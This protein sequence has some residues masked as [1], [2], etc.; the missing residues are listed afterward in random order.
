[1]GDR[2]ISSSVGMAGASAP[3]P[4]ARPLAELTAAAA[5]LVLFLDAAVET[6]RAESGVRWWVAGAA[7]LYAIATAATWR[8]RIAWQ[9]R[10]A[11][12]VLGMLGLIAATAWWPDGLTE[13]IRVVGQ[14]TP[15]VLAALAA[16]GVALAGL[17]LAHLPNLHLT[18]RGAIGALALYGVCAFVMA[19]IESRSLAALFAGES[20][21]QRLPAVLQG[22]FIGGVLVLPLGLISSLARTGLRRPPHM[23]MRAEV[24]KL[25]AL[26]TSMAI[27]LAGLPLRSRAA[28]GQPPTG[29]LMSALGIDPR[30]PKP[31]PAALNAALANSLRA[32]ED[33]ER[34]MAR[35]R[36]DP[37]YVAAALGSDP[38]RIFSWVQASTFW[39]PYRGLLRGPVGVLMDRLGNSLD[40]AVLL[41]TLLGQAGRPV[42]LARGPLSTEQAIRVLGPLIAYR[43][44]TVASGVAEAEG[45]DKAS[46]IARAY[47]LDESSIRRTL[48]AQ[49]GSLLRKGTHLLAQ[50]PD[51]TSRLALAVGTRPGPATT[52]LQRALEALQDHWWVQALDGGTWQDFD[53]LAAAAGGAIA[54][55]TETVSLD[56]VPTELRH[57]FT[58]RVIAE[59]WINGTL[60]ER[61][62]LQHT[63]VPADLIGTPIVLR[64]APAKWPKTFPQRDK[65][66]QDSLRTLALEQQEWTPALVVGRDPT[67]QSTIR[68]NGELTPIK[69]AQPAPAG[70]M[71]RL[72]DALNDAL[73]PT[74]TP[75]PPPASTPASSGALTSAWIE[76]ELQR[77]GEPAE[78]TRRA[79]FDLI[80]PAAR[81]ARPTEAPRIDDTGRL[82]R[83]LALMM[84]TEILPIVCRVDPGYVTHLAAQSVLANRDL[85]SA[86]VR[87]DFTE[88]FAGA[89]QVAKRLAPLPTRLYGLAL[90]RFEWSRF[91]SLI[92]ID[93]PNVLTRHVF[94]APAAKGFKLVAATDIVAN[95]V[96]VDLV[97]A[98]PSA[99]RLAQGVLDTN[100]EAIL[101]SDR[102]NASNAGW[103]FAADAS[104]MTLRSPGDPQLG[105]LQLSDDVRRRIADDLEAGY[106]V[107]APKAPVAVG[108]EAFSGWWRINPATGH[109]LG[110]GSTGWGQEYVEYLITKIPLMMLIEAGAIAFL[111]EYLLCRIFMSGGGDGPVARGCEPA[112]DRRLALTDFFV[113]PLHAAG[114]N[115][116]ANAL[117][118]AL[119]AAALG[120]L[121]SWAASKYGRGGGGGKADPS[122]KTQPDPAAKTPTDP[123]G[124][125]QAD[126]LAKTEP[127]PGGGNPGPPGK[128]SPDGRGAK[129]QE[130][131][132]DVE[133]D[134]AA[135]EAA[136][137]KENDAWLKIWQESKTRADAEKYWQEWLDAWT[138]LSRLKVA[139]GNKDMVKRPDY[140]F[141]EMWLGSEPLP[142]PPGGT[143]LRTGPGGTQI[144]PGPGGTKIIPL[145]SVSPT[146]PA[147]PG[148]CPGPACPPTPPTKAQT[149]LGGVLN[150]LG[151]KS[152]G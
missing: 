63:L 43:H 79:V 108:N 31:P 103:A 57:Q 109:A 42:R 26:T 71:S 36:W 130:G 149:G 96:G 16:A 128:P 52:R 61:T 77:P 39:I 10:L 93:R 19:A 68:D 2:I 129:T 136:R 32:I 83:S 125:T 33:G 35:D 44:P 148:L 101:D 138:A 131:R 91:E 22:A 137:Q 105:A 94:V 5:G 124:K 122:A 51:Q 78:K 64:F 76:Y 141:P 85:L 87:G 45:A 17:A 73:G 126:P 55:P 146:T 134:G 18:I 143:P 75:A 118:A 56:A 8:M 142:A 102:P 110:F 86:A 30:A 1:M 20:L 121:G 112:S 92:H 111:F 145:P 66:P 144:I 84:E 15:T 89:Q 100:A 114:S 27:V 28:G 123:S 81:A 14:P 152:G 23:T 98:D 119:L 132:W 72:T 21:W 60:T 69:Q 48:E 151:Q 9:G 90:A 88:D 58:V 65:A 24:W 62:A 13:G 6:F 135:F 127:G 38:Q 104:W 50:V 107:I 59:Q 3:P 40:R 139:P 82:T 106:V 46:A 70:A 150:T 116:L 4:A 115:C 67:A 49:S 34:E 147:Q 120:G 99:V 117:I 133:P 7:A 74:P 11:S 140:P 47:Q 12:A 95:D 37:A 41:A 53:L 25:V 80:G 97:V 29:T 54:N 113:T